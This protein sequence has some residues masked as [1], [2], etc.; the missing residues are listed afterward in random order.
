MDNGYPS[1]N[2]LK[3]GTITLYPDDIVISDDSSAATHVA[4]SHPIYLEGGKEY[5][6]VLITDCPEYEVWCSTLGESDM[7]NSITID[8]QPVLGSLFK[9]QNNK[10]WTADQNSDLKYTL[11]RAKFDTSATAAIT[12]VNNNI[13]AIE[14]A[15]GAVTFKKDSG[16][17]EIECL[18]HGLFDTSESFVYLQFPDGEWAG[19]SSSDLTGEFLV[20]ATD[21]EKFRITLKNGLKAT[22]DLTP[23]ISGALALINY[24][25][26]SIIPNLDY[27]QYQG[28][29]V[30]WV[31]QTTSGK[32]VG[33]TSRVPYTPESSMEITY[34]R[35]KRLY[36]DNTMV[37][38]SVLNEQKCMSGNKSLS[39]MV[40]LSTES[41]LV[42]PMLYCNDFGADSEF[43]LYD[44]IINNPSDVTKDTFLGASGTE[45][46]FNFVTIPVN[47]ELQATMLKV[48]CEAN[49][50][51]QANLRVFYRASNG[52]DSEISSLDWVELDR[53]E[54]F[55]NSN[56]F[57]TPYDYEFTAD[58][59]PAF[60]TFQIKISGQS[61]IKS[62]VPIINNYRVLA[63]A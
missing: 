48:Y 17:V 27:M 63:I 44:N 61:S 4:F 23:L 50:P 5:C 42:S 25:Y 55:K 11:Y 53:P 59:I 32:T 14:L 7:L 8:K 36:M 19:V 28:T 34:N 21:N 15:T 2:I 9:S 31:L 46:R 1:P 37:V 40:N 38:A 60:S 51:Q 58:N 16:V 29:G 45:N 57:D 30:Q 35:L 26:D 22:E 12:F 54:V 41:D 52:A 20:E 56:M 47:L 62:K 18:N 24:G 3:G 33:D 10:T 6:I 49:V 39:F 13:P 43:V